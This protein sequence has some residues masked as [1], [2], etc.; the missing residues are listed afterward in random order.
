MKKLFIILLLAGTI[1]AIGAAAIYAQRAADAERQRNIAEA[2]LIALTDTVTLYQDS[3]STTV[4]LMQTQG[5]LSQ[6]SILLLNTTLARAIYE[7][8]QTIESLQTLRLDFARLQGS[9]ASVRVQLREDSLAHAGEELAEGEEE[10]QFDLEGPP[11]EGSLWVTYRPA[12]P[13]GLRTDLG[14]SPFAMTYSVGCQERVPVVN[15]TTPP[16]VRAT[17]ERGTVSEDV[18]NPVKPRPIF[19]FSWDRAIWMGVGGILGAVIAN[20]VDDG[21][22]SSNYV[23]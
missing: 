8:N 2:N 15:V 21:F 14:V 7:R 6:D 1:I 5:Q 22:R 4:S 19:S 16:W 17:P 12:A 13:W 11:I 20:W 3:L 23:R 18:C 10:A 9:Y